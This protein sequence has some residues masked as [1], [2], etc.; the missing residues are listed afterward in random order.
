VFFQDL[1][2]SAFRTAG[3]TGMSPVNTRRFAPDAAFCL[4][5]ALCDADVATDAASTSTFTIIGT[6]GSQAQIRF[7]GTSIQ[8]GATGSDFV[9]LASLVAAELAK[10]ATA[11]S[12]F[13]PGSG[14]ASFPHAY[15]SPGNVASALVKA[16]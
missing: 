9:A 4:P 13:V 11:F 7:D 1:D 6:D 2:D 12:T 16:Q 14:G 15:T 3:Q 10:I 5:A 8:L